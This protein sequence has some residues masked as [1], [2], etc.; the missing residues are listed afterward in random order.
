MILYQE[1]I[2]V[3][4]M[5]KLKKF[6]YLTE[7]K[8]LSYYAKISRVLSTFCAILIVKLFTVFLIWFSSYDNERIHDVVTDSN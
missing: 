1:N 2:E 3:K 7:K 5:D 8:Q 4:F 6:T